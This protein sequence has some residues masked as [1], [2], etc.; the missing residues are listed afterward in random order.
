MVTKNISIMEDAYKLLLQRKRQ[1]E[2]FSDVIRREFSKKGSILDGAGIW[3]DLTD[4]DFENMEKMRAKMKEITHAS[5]M[6]KFK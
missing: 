5:I 2:S 6:E 4:E 3:A 1:T